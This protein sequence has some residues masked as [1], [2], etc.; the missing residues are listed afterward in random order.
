MSIV[1]SEAAPI[2]YAGGLERLRRVRSTRSLPLAQRQAGWSRLQLAYLS[3]GDEEARALMREV[4][5]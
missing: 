3:V 2:A 5:D 4:P 1:G